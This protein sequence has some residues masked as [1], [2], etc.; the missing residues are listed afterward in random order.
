MS[1]KRVEICGGIA[2]GKTTL[3][4]LLAEYGIPA[5]FERFEQNPFWS[6]FYANPRRYA[7]E[8]EVTFLLQHYSQMR[9]AHDRNQTFVYD[10][11]FVQDWAYARANLIGDMLQ[12]F[13]V[14]HE[15]TM[16]QLPEPLLVIHLNCDPA[17]ELRRVRE[18]RRPQETSIQ[19]DYLDHLNEQI[20]TRVSE[21]AG[22]VPVVEIDSGANDFANDLQTR[23]RIAC[24]LL[25]AIRRLKS[26]A[27]TVA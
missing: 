5:E 12:T 11:S 9:D 27:G 21:V 7:F 20:R 15:Y 16:R 19:C 2:A 4:Q 8:T 1:H 24:F 22:T 10:T 25:D 13:L 23:D 3:A 26:G 6:S 18:R 17:I 14:V